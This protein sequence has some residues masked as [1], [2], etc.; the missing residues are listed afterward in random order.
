MSPVWEPMISRTA[1][2]GLLASYREG[3]LL[4]GRLP[5]VLDGV[6]DGFGVEVRRLR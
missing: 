3:E 2:D 1:L 4:A 5:L 6:L